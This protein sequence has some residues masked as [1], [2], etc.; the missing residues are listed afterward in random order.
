M[1][2]GARGGWKKSRNVMINN[3]GGGEKGRGRALVLKK[4]SV[5]TT[6][7]EAIYQKYDFIICG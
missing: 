7:Q 2:E 1:R 5:E 3:I 4:Y 6:R